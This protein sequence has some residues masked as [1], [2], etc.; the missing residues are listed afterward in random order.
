MFVYEFVKF[1]QIEDGVTL[2]VA[3]GLMLEHPLTLRF[4]EAVVR[5]FSSLH[6]QQGIL[7]F[8]KML[9]V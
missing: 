4:V 9:N 6:I 1:S 8:E 5:S 2:N 7:L 3:G